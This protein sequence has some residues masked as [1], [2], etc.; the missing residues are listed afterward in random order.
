[1]LSVNKIEKL[2]QDT[3]GEFWTLK[4]LHYRPLGSIFHSHAGQ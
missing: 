3:P 2:A 4:T 1:M